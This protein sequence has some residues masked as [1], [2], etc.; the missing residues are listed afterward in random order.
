MVEVLE[1]ARHSG[2]TRPRNWMYM[3]GNSQLRV[4][5]PSGKHALRVNFDHGSR[6][7]IQRNDAD[8]VTELGLFEPKQVADQF[9]NA[10]QKAMTR[11]SFDSLILATM[12]DVDNDEVQLSSLRRLG[13]LGPKAKHAAAKIESLLDHRDFKIRNQAATILL[14]VGESS[15]AAE[16]VLLD[17]LKETRDEARINALES[18]SIGVNSEVLVVASIE[19][20]HDQSAKVRVQAAA[21]VSNLEK[22]SPRAVSAIMALTNDKDGSVRNA[23]LSALLSMTIDPKRL[24]KLLQESLSDTDRAYKA[25]GYLFNHIDLARA[26]AEQIRNVPRTD[27]ESGGLSLRAATL[28]SQV[29]ID[30]PMIIPTLEKVLLSRNFCNV[31]AAVELGKL[32][33]RARPPPFRF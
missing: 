19:S 32:G 6:F 29:D 21:T 30:D 14:Q 25:M 27:R 13:K 3:K 10:F 15:A 12:L 18:I 16:R 23:S 28:M 33:A 20:T 9:M 17:S 7:W 11:A 5:T 22:D 8:T 31:D 26:C 24:L 4:V 1:S 2:G